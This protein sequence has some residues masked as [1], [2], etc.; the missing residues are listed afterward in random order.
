MSKKDKKKGNDQFQSM[1]D[2]QEEQKKIEKK[3]RKVK[4]PCSHSNSKGKI[5]V[6]FIKGTLAKCKICGTRF[7]FEA[8]PF[9]ELERAQMIMHNAVN[10]IKAFS[11]DPEK[12]S[13][14]IN[15]L[16][17][18]DY[19]SFEIVELYKRT[20][21]AFGKNN[22]NNKKKHDDDFGAYGITNSISLN[23]GKKKGGHRF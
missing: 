20:L 14:V 7:D 9:D 10:Q 16:G 18:F 13:S 21:N 8:I 6:D 15:T 23:G 12:E 22:K 1:R 2:L 19:N 4:I 11:D 17:D 5:K 3:L